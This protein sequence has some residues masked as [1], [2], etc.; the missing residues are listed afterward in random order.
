MKEKRSNSDENGGGAINCV[1]VRREHKA[2]EERDREGKEATT[3]R[4]A[5]RVK[6]CACVY[7]SVCLGVGWGARGWRGRQQTRRF[8]AVHVL[9]GRD[10]AATIYTG[11]GG[12]SVRGV[13]VGGL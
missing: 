7:V 2:R 6:Q 9:P 8:T 12:L 13:G 10:R 4:K 11:C 1:Q 3:I 5:K